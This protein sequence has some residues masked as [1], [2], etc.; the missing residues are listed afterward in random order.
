MDALY[1]FTGTTEDTFGTD[2][3]AQISDAIEATVQELGLR[4]VLGCPTSNYS[5]A[6]GLNVPGSL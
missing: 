1:A 2:L 3:G 6:A 4:E 5:Y